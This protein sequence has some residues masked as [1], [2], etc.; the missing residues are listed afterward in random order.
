M[1][2]FLAAAAASATWRPDPPFLPGRTPPLDWYKH[3]LPPG[4][5]VG[6]V[7]KIPARIPAYT[8]VTGGMPGWQIAVIAVASALLATALTVIVYRLRAARRR[9]TTNPA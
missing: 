9:V 1:S 3:H 5:V 6:P 7:Y 4:H 2:R 8:I